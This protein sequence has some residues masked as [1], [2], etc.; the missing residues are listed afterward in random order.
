MHE[1]F[2][3]MVCAPIKGSEPLLTCL[4]Y[5]MSIKLLSEHSLEFLSFNGRYTGSSKSTLVKTPHF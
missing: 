5:S 3:N 4:E 2:N 1:I